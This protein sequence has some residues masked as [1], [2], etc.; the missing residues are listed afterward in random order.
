M[1]THSTCYNMLHYQDT[2]TYRRT[3]GWASGVTLGMGDGEGRGGARRLADAG[4][5][6][7]A[8][9]RLSLPEPGDKLGVS[10]CGV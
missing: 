9:R 10:V 4:Q 7:E 8:H 2:H 5:G 3:H 6:E 1:H